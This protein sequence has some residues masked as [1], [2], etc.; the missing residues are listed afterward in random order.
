MTKQSDIEQSRYVGM[1]HFIAKAVWLNDQHCLS[2]S[3]SYSANIKSHQGVCSL[4]KCLQFIF[5]TVNKQ[6]ISWN[7]SN[8]SADFLCKHGLPFTLPGISGNRY[9]VC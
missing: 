8:T 5:V 7:I 3:I 6:N 1:S 2:E 4:G 9:S